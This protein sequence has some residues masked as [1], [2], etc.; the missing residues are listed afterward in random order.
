MAETTNEDK[1]EKK[2]STKQPMPK[3]C[4]IERVRF[5][6][7]AESMV[8]LFMPGNYQQGMP[9]GDGEGEVKPIGSLPCGVKLNKTNSFG[10]HGHG[11]I[12]TTVDG[13]NMAVQVSMSATIVNSKEAKD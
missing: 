10:W 9:V 1:K 7:K 2:K 6:E 11:K 5:M 8:L 12:H 4:A 3:R 13:V